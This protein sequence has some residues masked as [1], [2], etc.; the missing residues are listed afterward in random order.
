ME[1]ERLQC[2]GAQSF[3]QNLAIIIQPN[4]FCSREIEEWWVDER[5]DELILINIRVSLI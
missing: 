4:C 5:V 1:R 2:K 3:I